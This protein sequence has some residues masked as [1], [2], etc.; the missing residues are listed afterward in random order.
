[1]LCGLVVVLVVVVV[2]GRQPLHLSRQSRR[3]DAHL[4]LHGTFQPDT[5]Q[6]LARP[7]QP[8]FRRGRQE[9]LAMRDARGSFLS[10][11]ER[12][13]G[14]QKRLL[15]ARKR[16]LGAR[17]LFLSARNR[18][19]GAREHFVSGRGNEEEEEED[20][21]EGNRLAGVQ[22]IIPYSYIQAAIY[23]Y[24]QGLCTVSLTGRHSA[25]FL[26]PLYFLQFPFL[27]TF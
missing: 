13:L 25:S 15:G 26:L 6:Q 9:Q 18:F 3:E 14:A 4:T 21:V 19:M 16:F 12:F 5:P 22:V 8:L 1:M 24:I 17:E 23:S 10:A 2:M 27:C 20:R 7:I 11:M